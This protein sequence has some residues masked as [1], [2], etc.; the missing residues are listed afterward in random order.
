LVVDEDITR[1]GQGEQQLQKG[2]EME[3][4]HVPAI[5]LVQ[6][7]VK[8]Y[9]CHGNPPSF[10]ENKRSSV[11]GIIARQVKICKLFAKL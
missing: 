10:V 9:I 6:L 1:T 7:K 11:T 5:I 8:F 2:V 4:T 3:S